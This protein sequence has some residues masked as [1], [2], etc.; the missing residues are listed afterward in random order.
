M[1]YL[2]LSVNS[3]PSNSKGDNK[4][5]ILKPLL[6]PPVQL[7]RNSI[8]KQLHGPHYYAFTLTL[9]GST[10]IWIDVAN[11]SQFSRLLLRLEEGTCLHHRFLLPSWYQLNPTGRS[12]WPPGLNLGPA[13]AHLLG[14]RVR[15][16]PGAMDVFLF[17]VLCVF[18]WRSLWQDNYATRGVVQNVECLSVIS[19]PRQCTGRGPLG[20]IE[21]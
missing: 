2:Q 7:P 5:H 14:L 1:E 6:Q 4:Q 21:S 17:W 15:I 18:R 16:P 8:S 20:D 10:C 9:P 13:D 11:S 12:R 3:T 19:K